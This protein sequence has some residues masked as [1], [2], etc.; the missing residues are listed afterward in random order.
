MNYDVP[1]T[2]LAA[3]GMR[4]ASNLLLSNGVLGNHGSLVMESQRRNVP[5]GKHC[6]DPTRIIIA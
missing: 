1:G 2:G 6:D 4:L 5:R 3:G